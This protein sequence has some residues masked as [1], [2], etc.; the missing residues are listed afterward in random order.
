MLFN[1]TEFLFIFLPAV[2]LLFYFVKSEYKIF[3]IGFASIAF[4]YFS[5]FVAGSSLFLTILICF[6]LSKYSN[7]L[8][9]LISIFLPLFILFFY[10]YYDFFFSDFLDFFEINSLK[11]QNLPIFL[12]IALPAGVSF[13]TFQIISFLVD[14]KNTEK[15][16]IK[17]I[18]F[19]TYITFFPQLIAGPI[20]RWHEIKTQFESIKK[21]KH[22]I[23]FYDAIKFF[24]IGLFLKI[25][26]ADICGK[27]SSDYYKLFS[28]LINQNLK[29]NFFDYI[30]YNFYL[31][32]QI[33]FDFFSY[34]I[35]AIG[36]G[37]LFGIKL[38]KN[39]DEPYMSKN[40]KEFWRKWHI[41]LSFWVKDYIYIPLGGSKFYVRNILIIFLIVGLWHGASMNFLIWGL[42]HAVLV[43]LYSFSKSWW[44]KQITFIQISLT[45]IIASSAWPLFDLNISEIYY[46]FKNFTIEAT[47]S[48]FNGFFFI[49]KIIF[50]IYFFLLLFIVFRISISNHLY[51]GLK[52]SKLNLFIF[53]MIFLLC[54][55]FINFTQSFIY[56]RF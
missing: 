9:F 4:Y 5:G 45:F 41:T 50:I 42:F 1:S 23:K 44:D 35:M 13:Y 37:Y 29:I 49:K 2:L 20:V 27:F 18:D 56:F 28:Q 51:N 34:S 54:I 11:K 24:T 3:I 16:N 48:V 26:I 52:V 15:K 7:R 40:I 21:N 32:F 30:I 12:Q 46:I 39:F 19:F 8:L 43:S 22:V 10:K 55:I 31:T 38:P 53:A 14:N 6:L 25:F 33:Y 36:L 47:S 17:F